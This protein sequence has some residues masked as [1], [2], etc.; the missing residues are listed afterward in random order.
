[1]QGVAGI[2]FIFDDRRRRCCL[3]RHSET[4]TFVQEKL[5]VG[6][7]TFGSNDA[8]SSR[9]R[10]SCGPCQHSRLLPKL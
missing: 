5:A 6:G 10:P 2:G 9:A 3:G 1:M 8:G 7:S 4:L